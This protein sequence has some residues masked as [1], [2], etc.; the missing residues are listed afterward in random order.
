[1][2]KSLFVFTVCAITGL[3]KAADPDNQIYDESP[4]GRFGFRESSAGGQ[5]MTVVL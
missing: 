1:L 2:N 5:F 3:A 4:D